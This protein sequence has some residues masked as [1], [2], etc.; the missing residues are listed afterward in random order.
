[1]TQSDQNYQPF[2]TAKTIATGTPHQEGAPYQDKL[3]ETICDPSQ[4][5]P[6]GV[7]RVLMTHPHTLSQCPRAIEFMMRSM[8]NRRTEKG[9]FAS[10]YKWSDV[11]PVINKS[12]VQREGDGECMHE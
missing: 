1:M 4:T 10:E 12:A 6:T 2:L 7:Q 5:H 3:D 9:K 8:V 11:Y